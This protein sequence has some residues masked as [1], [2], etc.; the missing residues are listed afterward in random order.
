M[1]AKTDR[2]NRP[3]HNEPNPVKETGKTGTEVAEG[4]Q[5]FSLLK[6]KKILVP[7]DFS[8]GARKA[9]RYAVPFAKTFGASLSLVHVV[10]PPSFPVDMPVYAPIRSEE[11]LAQEAKSRLFSLADEDVDEFVPVNVH[12][13]TGQ[14]YR[15]VTDL[16][17]ELETDLIIIAT[18]GYTGLTH[19]LLG[20]T[21]EKVARYAPCPVLIV[22][23]TEHEFI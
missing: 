17:K 7:I 5:G 12:V 10:E 9:L 21:A 23:E 1:Q 2:K 4:E 16:A 15:E 14:A 18:H 19:L 20:S 22:R 13:R 8:E 6:I 11:E 3:P